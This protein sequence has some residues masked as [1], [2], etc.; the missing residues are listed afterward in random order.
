MSAA[1]RL[2]STLREARRRVAFD[3]ALIIA[4]LI[5]AAFAVTWR[6]AGPGAGVAVAMAIAALGVA[7]AGRR[8]A[9]LDTAWMVGALNA[10]RAD[11]DDSAG[12]LFAEVS[13]LGPL[14]RLQRARLTQRIERGAPMDLR[15]PWSRR[16]QAA[17]AAVALIVLAASLLW[18]VRTPTPGDALPRDARSTSA[19]PVAPRL[20]E[21]RLR[22]EPP[23]YTRL[24]ARDQTTLDTKA[25]QGSRLQ[26][27]LRFAPQPAAVAL[28]FHDGRRLPLQNEGGQWRVA[29]ILAK[30]ALYRLEVE[31]TDVSRAL[32]RLDAIT[33][34]V[35]EVAV[36]TPDRSLSLVSP[37]QRHWAIAFDAIDDYG[38]AATAQL[39]VVMAQGSGENILFREQF[40]TLRGSGPATRRRFAHTLDLSALGLAE[41]DDLIV[42]LAVEDNRTPLAQRARSAS[43][44]LRW[45]S[46]LGTET[47]GLEGMVR[48]V[49]PAYFRSQRQIILDAEALLKQRRSLDAERF[50]QRSDEVGVDQRILR[51]RYGQFLGE[52]TEDGP[53]L[54]THDADEEHAD[55]DAHDHSREQAG[56]A[57]GHDHGGDVPSGSAA[58]GREAAVLEAYGHTHD[59]AEAATLLDPETRATLKAALDEMW[60]SELNLRQGHPERAL[61]YAY[62]ALEFIKKVQQA[63]RIY[64]ARVGPELPPIDESRRLGGERSGLSRREDVLVPATAPDPTLAALWRA[65]QD[66]PSSVASAPAPIDFP[67]LERWLR[68]HPSQL[69]DPLAFVAAIEALRAEPGCARCRADL[70]ALL[71]PL[72]PRPPATVPRRDDGGD[73]G[74]RYLESLR[75]G[76]AR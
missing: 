18:P 21:Q 63:S 73:E 15:A 36:V 75:A 57:D 27:T 5:V 43:L 24:P 72:L 64:L 30:S 67:R 41:G 62:R 13:A 51:L 60:Q 40:M 59:H 44:I 71:W 11:L 55:E 28:V 38:V 37:G 26:W 8:V 25:P 34:R 2:A 16:V 19:A 45:P 7:W 76:Q 56:G 53:K 42:Q 54:P 4:P 6:M 10:R 9:R 29:D 66:A 68:D 22:V 14:E 32:H 61:P 1:E 35:P 3:T 48:K 70:R 31:G 50:T 58:F 46:N 17:A 39:R 69:A 52:E 49:M 20:V 23:A 47:S 12:L 74:R 33:D 65:L